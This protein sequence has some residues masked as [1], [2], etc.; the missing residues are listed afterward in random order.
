[1][2]LGG[3]QDENHIRRR[4]LQSLQKRVKRR[5]REHMHL[6][7]DKHAVATLR[8]GHQHLVGKLAD[9]VDT[10]V[11]RRVKLQY[12]QRTVLVELPTRAALVTR[13]TLRGGMFAIYGLGENTG[14]RS[15][16]HPA[17]PAEKIGMRQPVG[18]NSITQRG[19]ERPLPH[20]RRKCRW[21]VLPRRHYIVFF[22]KHSFKQ[23]YANSPTS[24]NGITEQTDRLQSVTTDW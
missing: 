16:P 23:R 1:M 11:R 9:V 2:L 22:H 20:H 24:S 21:P 19:R 5:L 13:V 10:V 14:T 12:I 17:R 8:R 3:G 7:D 6:V 15:L 18:C 4:F